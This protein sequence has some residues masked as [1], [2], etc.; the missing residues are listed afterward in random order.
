MTAPGLAAQLACLIEATARKPGNVHRLRDFDD[1]TYPDFL[2]SAA[3][4]GP[5]MEAA[6][7][8][9][10]GAAVLEAVRATRAVVSTNT[11][12]G[13][14]LLL[15]PLAAVPDG[16]EWRAGVAAVLGGLTVE[17]SRA[18]FEAIRLANPG[19]LGRADDQDV[20]GEP[21]LP[22]REVMA[23]AADRDGVARQYA[24]GYPDV[25]DV[26]VPA[27][28]DGVARFGLE[29]AV[30]FCHLRLMAA[31]PDTLIARKRGRATAEESA[32]LAAR[33]LAA[34]WPDH[35]AAE[36]DHLDAWLRA[37]GHARNPGTTA[38]LVTAALFVCLRAGSVPL[39]LRP[40]DLGR[41]S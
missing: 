8:I 22:L 7:R 2:L 14:V 9:G 5:A 16:A 10:V 17:D 37:D 28:A 4:I 24:L 15:A 25:F 33:V 39:P 6:R 11:N 36:L 26:G 30:V 13:I 21:T 32:R 12:L 35:G 41:A 38:D 1:L 19:G 20:G 18:V 3:A 29:R 23:L 27:L 34:G 40:G 31:L